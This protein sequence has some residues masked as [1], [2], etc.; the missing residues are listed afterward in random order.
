MVDREI[1]LVGA[2]ALLSVAYVLPSLIGVVRHGTGASRIVG[3]NVFLGWSLIGWIWALFLACR[4]P[5][6]PIA[7]TPASAEWIPWLPG[8]PEAADAPAGSPNTY[9]DGT[10][11]ISESGAARTWAVCRAGRWGIAY[12]LDGIQRTAAWVDSSDIPVGVLAHA[13]EPCPPTKRRT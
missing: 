7:A 11:L 5:Q 3:I 2:C 6:A 4:A 12:E 9:A 8:R 1:W 10:Y 13:L